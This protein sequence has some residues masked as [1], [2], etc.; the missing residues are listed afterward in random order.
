M[1]ML[2]CLDNIAEGNVIVK[3]GSTSLCFGIRYLLTYFFLHTI[4]ILI[5]I[6]CLTSRFGLVSMV[7][8][9]CNIILS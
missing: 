7:T 6:I 2:Q 8:L 9:V 1:Y 5:F 4:D 3:H